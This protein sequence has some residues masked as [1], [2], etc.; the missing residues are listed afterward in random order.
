MRFVCIVKLVYTLG[1]GGRRRFY[2]YE[3]TLFRAIASLRE[4]FLFD[5]ETPTILPQNV[6]VSLTKQNA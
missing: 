6:P 3:D 5:E 4:A 2:L 1:D